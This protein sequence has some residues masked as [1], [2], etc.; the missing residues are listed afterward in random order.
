[1][2]EVALL[3]QGRMTPE[4]FERLELALAKLPP[5]PPANQLTRHYWAPG[6]YV[7]E[8]FIPAG[9]CLT[10]KIHLHE[11][12]SM[13]LGDITVATSE[14]MKRVTGYQVVTAPAGVKRAAITH[15]DTWWTNIHPNPD[16]ERDLVKLA[17]RYVV[18]DF[19]QLDLAMGVIA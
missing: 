18:D 7:R 6:V 2:N 5:M 17:A 12:I 1:M 9:V 15:A 11:N 13:V 19:D 8:L 14:G 16:N 10:G 3:M 4:K